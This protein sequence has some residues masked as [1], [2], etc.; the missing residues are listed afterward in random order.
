MST[1][2]NFDSLLDYENDNLSDQELIL[3]ES[4]ENQLLRDDNYEE[5]EEEG[6][7]LEVGINSQDR[8]QDEDEDDNL[9]DPEAL[10]NDEP[11]DRD[12]RVNPSE[13]RVQSREEFRPRGFQRTRG[14][15]RGGRGQHFSINSSTHSLPVKS[16]YLSTNDLR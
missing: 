7:M 2:E 16:T 8:F 4:E 14:R 5:E 1:T 12:R 11:E 6:D 15:G 10:V 9:S 13:P 3:D